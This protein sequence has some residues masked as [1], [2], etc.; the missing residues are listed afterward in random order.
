MKIKNEADL[1]HWQREWANYHVLLALAQLGLFDL[2]L[3]NQSHS[4]KEISEWL[5]ADERALRICL[6]ILILSDLIQFDVASEAFRITPSGLAFAD[7]LAM[8]KLE[9]NKRLNY[10]NVLEA[11]KTGNP[12]MSTTGGVTEQDRQQAQLFLREMY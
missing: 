10:A 11:L 1:T 5:Q 9:W 2:L 6:R 8:L 12:V 4:I 7:K 3:D